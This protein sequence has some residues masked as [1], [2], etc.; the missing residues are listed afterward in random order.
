MKR[1]FFVGNRNCLNCCLNYR[2]LQV[3]IKNIL[4]LIRIIHTPQ[5]FKL[6]PL[7]YELFGSVWCVFDIVLI[8]SKDNIINLLRG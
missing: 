6:E 3:A 2:A 5:T 4:I 7:M 1:F 8:E